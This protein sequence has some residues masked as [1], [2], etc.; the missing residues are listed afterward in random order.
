M[1]T[2]LPYV[3][4]AELEIDPAQLESFKSAIRESVETAVRVEPGVLALYAVSDQDHP[5]RVRVFEIYADADA[6]KTHLETPHF[7]KFRATTETMVT[8][9][10]LINAVPIAL[11]DKAK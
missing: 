11:S 2:K 6:Y 3:R 5:A 8:S 7:K 1:D 4:I 9:R 10:T